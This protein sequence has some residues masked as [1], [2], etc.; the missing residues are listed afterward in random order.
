MDGLL[1]RICLQL[2]LLH[3]KLQVHMQMVDHTTQSGYFKSCDAVLTKRLTG[4]LVSP[5]RNNT[6]LEE[7]L[8]LTEEDYLLASTVV[9]GFS[10]ADKMWR[11]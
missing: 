6:S 1:S 8:E 2:I 11:E 10:L 4:T 3:L 9:H 7:S 5:E